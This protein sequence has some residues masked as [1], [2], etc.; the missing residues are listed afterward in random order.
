M[1]R[2]SAC[3]REP[4]TI[5]LGN[6]CEI[7][8]TEV[9]HYQDERTQLR[10]CYTRTPGGFRLAQG[11]GRGAIQVLGDSVEVVIE[12]STPSRLVVQQALLS[13]DTTTQTTTIAYA[14]KAML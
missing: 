12:K 3:L 8:P 14:R 2:G 4:T 1:G 7:T 11:R 6:W 5:G 13:S 9:R 10:T